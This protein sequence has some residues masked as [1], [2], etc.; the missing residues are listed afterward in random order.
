MKRPMRRPVRETVTV[1]T[2]YQVPGESV[3]PPKIGRVWV[4]P[5]K[6][7]VMPEDARHLRERETLE[8]VA[9][10]TR[11][12]HGLESFGPGVVTVPR[13]R[14]EAL[15]ETE[16]NLAASIDNCTA[17]RAGIIGIRNGSVAVRQ[18]D[19]ATFDAAW[20]AAQPAF[21]TGA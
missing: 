17:Q 10:S 15:R 20:M 2:R 13:W 21:A 18:V 19:Y 16:R 4:G 5:G 14:A 12:F 7:R 3:F 1:T 11:H 9:L 8:D 6:V